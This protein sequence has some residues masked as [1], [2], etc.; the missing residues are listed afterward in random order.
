MKKIIAIEGMSC[1]HCAGR[2]TDALGKIDNVDNVNVNLVEKTATVELSQDVNDIQLKEAVQDVGY[3][4][5]EIQS[6]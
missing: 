4:V 5:T 6:I 2:V 3:V 1:G